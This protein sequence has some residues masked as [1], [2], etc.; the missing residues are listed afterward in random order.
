MTIP[1]HS[2]S[3]YSIFA[4]I[5]LG[6]MI[7]SYRTGKLS[8]WASFIGGILTLC[9]FLGAGF[10][11]LSILI[12]FFVLGTGATFWKRKNKISL[13][14][15]E[16]NQGKRDAWQVLA[17]AGFAAILGVSCLLFPDHS[18]L[19]SVM[20]AAAFASATSDT[21]SSELGN[22][23]GRRYY[24]ILTLKKDLRG[25]NGVVSM[26]GTLFG[27]VGATLI[28]S[29]Y[30]AGASD[31]TPFLIIIISGCI[32][33]IVDSILGASLE[34][35]GQLNNNAVNFMNTVSGA[36]TALIFC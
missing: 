28:A 18:G 4:I 19:F 13:G 35:H 6:G 36:M 10:T 22:I 7:A 27:T 3:S 17:N 5:V 20:I 33:N 29:I 31:W 12:T 8:L 11:G 34:R 23:Y 24:N 2:V 26:E 14:L 1:D 21:L 15:E 9:I 32:G 25:L 16:A 30:C